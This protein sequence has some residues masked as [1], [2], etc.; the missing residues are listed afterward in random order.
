VLIS[1]RRRV[2]IAAMANSL[3]AIVKHLDGV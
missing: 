1:G 2:L 3:R